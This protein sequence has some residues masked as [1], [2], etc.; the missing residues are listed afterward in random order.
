MK[1]INFFFEEIPRFNIN[2]KILREIIILIAENEQ[3][4]C[5][6]INIIFCRDEYLH[7]LNLQFLNHDYYTDIV[8][9]DYSDSKKISGELYISVERI[10]ENAEKL[11]SHLDA[12]NSV[13][14]NMLGAM[15]YKK[16]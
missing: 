10:K 16:K 11:N 7:R 1:K 6:K 13:Y 3:Y 12:L 15:N 8:T 2:R 9:F 5:N 4:A 14:G